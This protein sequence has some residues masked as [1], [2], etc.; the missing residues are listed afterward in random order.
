MT[1]MEPLAIYLPKAG[2]WRAA[3]DAAEALSWGARTLG[4]DVIETGA[5][6]G[7]RRTVMFLPHFAKLGIAK[8]PRAGS[9]LF[10]LEQVSMESGWI[11]PALPTD[12]RF[13]LPFGYVVWDYSRRNVAALSAMQISARFAGMGWSE[14]MRTR[15]PEIPFHAK[16]YDVCFFGTMNDRRQHI[17]G[18]MRAAGL[19]VAYVQRQ[20][21]RDRDRI[22]EASKIVLNVHYYSAKVFESVRVLPQLAA[23]RIVLTE[24]GGDPEAE[25]LRPAACFAPYD[26]LV[27]EAKRLCSETE[28]APYLAANEKALAPFRADRVFRAIL[29][30]KRS[31]ALPTYLELPP[32]APGLEQVYW[33]ITQSAGDLRE[34]LPRLRELAASAASIALLGTG[35]GGAMVAL[36]AGQPRALTCYDREMRSE[37]VS[38]GALRLPVTSL[39]LHREDP[40]K[41]AIETA[42]VLVIDDEPTENLRVHHARA[43]KTIAVHGSSDPATWKAIEE[44]LGAR[45]WGLVEKRQGG[46]GLAVLRRTR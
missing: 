6:D 45:S 20:W 34:H 36:L 3:E 37:A 15:V 41:T 46:K 42:E 28:R 43:T 12:A 5:P 27:E 25:P 7:A 2:W 26:R 17:L 11:S 22:A 23:R 33:A 44:L 13:A 19:R 18:E 14:P 9:I 1:A 30:E 4:Y 39:E 31:F 21:G 10:N 38:L 29:E 8:L 24:D 40:K 16:A 35:F 32:P